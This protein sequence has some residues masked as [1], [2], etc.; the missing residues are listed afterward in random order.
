M[1][2]EAEK[3]MAAAERFIAAARGLR[4]EIGADIPLQQVMILAYL[5]RHGQSNQVELAR[6]LDLKIAAASRHCRSLSEF[7]VQSGDLVKAKG[8]RLIVADRHQLKSREMV[9]KLADHAKEYLS[10]FLLVLADAD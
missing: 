1:S 9:Y 8:Q 7:H 5:F 4:Q 3:Q 10:R 2:V 6:A